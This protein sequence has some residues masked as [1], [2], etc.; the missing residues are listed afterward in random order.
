MAGAGLNALNGHKKKLSAADK[1]VFDQEDTLI[2]SSADVSGSFSGI[3]FPAG[4]LMIVAEP[5]LRKLVGL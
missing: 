5:A 3:S 4:G 1:K 2:N